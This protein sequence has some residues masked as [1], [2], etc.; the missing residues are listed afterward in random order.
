MNMCLKTMLHN[1]MNRTD[2]PC[3]NM[4]HVKKRNEYADNCSSFLSSSN[5]IPELSYSLNEVIAIN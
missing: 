2:M 4:L 1:I 3:D 5:N